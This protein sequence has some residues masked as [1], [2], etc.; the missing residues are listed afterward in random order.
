MVNRRTLLLGVGGTIG[1]AGCTGDPDDEGDEN[2]EE[3]D[4]VFEF[5]EVLSDG[6][7][8]SDDDAVVLG[9]YV[10][11]TGSAAAEQD[12]VFEIDGETV[13][14]EAVT[15]EP[16]DGTNFGGQWEST[17]AF[18]PG[19]HTYTLRSSND[20]VTATF[21]IEGSETDGSATQSFSGTGEQ[22][23]EGIEID[24]GLTVLEATHSGESNFQVSLVDGSDVVGDFVDV[25]GDFDGAQAALIGSG[26]YLL[27]VDADGS[28][29]VDIYQPR[30]VTGESP[31]ESLSGN[32]P[33]VVG[34]IGFDGTHMAE[35]SHSGTGNFQVQVLPMVGSSP[36]ILF[37]ETGEFGGQTTFAFDGVG[38]IDVNADGDWSLAIE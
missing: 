12:I 15:L 2:G 32:G 9:A 28:W 8:Y 4:G 13:A 25:S 3:R 21:T 30:S 10:E 24:G 36:E 27:D 6:E 34:P 26:E 22:G 19:E 17:S 29:T 37:D 38:W 33:D 5:T 23:E 1:I 7:S 11:N 35:A 14:D 20:Q 18:E 31:P 16:G